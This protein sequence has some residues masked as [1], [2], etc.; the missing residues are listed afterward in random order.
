VEG[1]ASNTLG[2]TPERRDDD[3]AEEVVAEVVDEGVEQGVEAASVLGEEEGGSLEDVGEQSNIL[4]HTSMGNL[5]R[6][7]LIIN[8][9]VHCLVRT[10]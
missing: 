7:L 4:A 9:Y 2:G 3:N 6:F 1:T 8:P 5:L 10:I